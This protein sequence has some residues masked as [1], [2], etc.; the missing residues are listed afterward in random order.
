[1]QSLCDSLCDGEIS[2]LLR[3]IPIGTLQLPQGVY[4]N[5]RFADYFTLGRKVEFTIDA[6]FLFNNGTVD[7]NIAYNP[8]LKIFTRAA[9]IMGAE[10]L[11]AGLIAGEVPA[12]LALLWQGQVTSQSSPLWV[13]SN[14]GVTVYCGG[15]NA[16]LDTA[17]RTEFTYP[18]PIYTG[19]PRT[20]GNVDILVQATPLLWGTSGQLPFQLGAGD[21][22]TAKITI[23]PTNMSGG[24]VTG[25]ISVLLVTGVLNSQFNQ[26]S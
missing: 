14:M 24:M 23:S 2:S 21:K 26:G 16:F 5:A 4:T 13:S 11:P 6:G 12:M 9:G 17:S 18:E 25:T 10:V 15:A 3:N 20:H 8:A 19:A 1:M 22:G 7:K